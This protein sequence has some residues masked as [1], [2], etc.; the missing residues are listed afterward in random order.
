[1]S[2]DRFESARRARQGKRGYQGAKSSGPRITGAM[3][4]KEK[5]E[6]E[7]R[8]AARPDVWVRA[9][10]IRGKGH[11]NWVTF[12]EAEWEAMTH[13]E[14]CCYQ[15]QRSADP[16]NKFQLTAKSS[17]RKGTLVISALSGIKR[18]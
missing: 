13:A 15:F 18:Y 10:R 17:G 7:A 9:Q 1:M 4:E 8:E 11:R 2:E 5:R 14:R 12:S 3:L 16:G 6:Q